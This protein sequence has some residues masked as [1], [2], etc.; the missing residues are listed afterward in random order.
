MK[1]D[2]ET[3]NIEITKISDKKC[4]GDNNMKRQRMEEKHDEKHNF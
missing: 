3:S 1:S 4:F 2:P